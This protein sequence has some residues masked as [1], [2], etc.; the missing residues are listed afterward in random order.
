MES[1]PPSHLQN[2]LKSLLRIAIKQ[3]I[4]RLNLLRR[5]RPDRAAGPARVRPHTIVNDNSQVVSE[6]LESRPNA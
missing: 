5:P 4:N 3:V 6:L 2:H 1:T